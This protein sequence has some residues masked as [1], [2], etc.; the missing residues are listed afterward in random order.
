MNKWKETLCLPWT[1]IQQLRNSTVTHHMVSYQ[2]ENCGSPIWPQWSDM[3]GGSPE[4]SRMKCSELQLF[5]NTK[6][7]R[8]PYLEPESIALVPGEGG[9]QI[10]MH[11]CFW[12]SFHISMSHTSDTQW[13]I[14]SQKP[15][16]PRSRISHP[17]NLEGTLSD[18]A[19]AV[20]NSLQLP[21]ALGNVSLSPRPSPP[22]WAYEVSS[23]RAIQSS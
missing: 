2:D 14:T 15:N 11:L 8:L 6:D 10:G 17:E 9:F 20:T 7:R 12:R 19:S 5:L 1:Q 21:W 13:H 3:H 18:L 16:V 23:V 22:H 4:G